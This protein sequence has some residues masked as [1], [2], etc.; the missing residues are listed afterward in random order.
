MT[1]ISTIIVLAVAL[2]GCSA[3][4]HADSAA[5]AANGSVGVTGSASDAMSNGGSTSSSMEE[6]RIKMQH[7]NTAP[8]GYENQTHIGS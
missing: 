8:T 3:M 7:G 5:A 4:E 1:K 6:Q 2:S